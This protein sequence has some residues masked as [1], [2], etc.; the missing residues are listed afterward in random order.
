MENKYTIHVNGKPSKLENIFDIV[1]PNRPD[2]WYKVSS[3]DIGRKIEDVLK[4]W[5]NTHETYFYLNDKKIKFKLVKE[6]IKC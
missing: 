3:E 2:L 1:N 4:E 5:A 6:D